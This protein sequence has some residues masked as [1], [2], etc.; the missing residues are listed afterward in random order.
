MSDIHQKRVTF[1][2]KRYLKKY[3]DA[4]DKINEEHFALFLAEEIAPNVT[5]ATWRAYRASCTRDFIKNE[6]A[7]KLL[8]NG[9][10]GQRKKLGKKTSS[11]RAKRL[12][13]QDLGLLSE[14]AAQEHE[15]DSRSKGKFA[16][17]WLL[18]GW[19]T[20]LRP[21]EWMTA[22]I[23]GNMLHIENS[24]LKKCVT[25]DWGDRKFSLSYLQEFEVEFIHEFIQEIQDKDE[26]GEGYERLDKL[27][28]RA[29]AWLRK[30]NI[31]LFPRRKK[32]IGLLSGRHQFIANMKSSGQYT[33]A[34]IAY[35]VGHASDWRA[36]ESYGRAS[37]GVND[38][39][40]P[41]I[42]D[43]QQADIDNVRR[44]FDKKLKKMQERPR[45]L[46]DKK[47]E[48]K[49]GD[50]DTHPNEGLMY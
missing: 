47:A 16:I 12:S 23:E 30:A 14:Y 29:T 37:D 46:T 35:I 9:V 10:P 33:P 41:E 36:F 31:A 32:S 44:H 20:G 26:L 3:P 24:K 17:R 28:K 45:Y 22:F 38:R 15:R 34:E 19:L 39:K 18:A 27:R 42:G 13:N 43:D 5:A 4:I 49:R 50:D 21:H 40:M 8:R 48:D 11:L 7:I 2:C 25:E 6:Q 1:L